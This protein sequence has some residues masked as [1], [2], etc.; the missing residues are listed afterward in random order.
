MSTHEP[1]TDGILRFRSELRLSPGTYLPIAATAIRLP[2]GGVWLHSPID[3]SDEDVAAIEA[4]GPVKFIVAPSGL[5]HLFARAAAARWPAATVVASPAVAT[6]QPG[7]AFL[8]LSAT[9]RPWGDAIAALPIDGMPDVQEWAFYHEPSRTL[10]VVDL[11]FHLLHTHGLGS[12]LTYTLVGTRGRLASS[13][14]FRYF[15]KDAAAHWASVDQVLAWP[16]DRLL[17]CHGEP[18]DSGAHPLVI[19]ALRVVR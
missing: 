1:I 3:F 4:L 12:Y 8:P 10:L 6:K 13:R 5:H 11:L 19:E 16:F 15:I 7:L 17:P 14:L 2:D 18:I 9:E